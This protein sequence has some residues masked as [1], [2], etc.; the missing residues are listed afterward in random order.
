[1]GGVEIL[2]V[3]RPPLALVH[4]FRKFLVEFFDGVPGPGVGVVD[5]EADA[6]TAEQEDDTD[7][8]AHDQRHLAA[9]LLDRRF[10]R[11]ALATPRRRRRAGRGPGLGGC[12]APFYPP[13][14][15][16]RPALSPSA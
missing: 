10:V 2:A 12:A 14:P 16:L 7:D 11:I 3:E 5:T 6:A 13:P 15:P 9:G 1:H 4:L 8:A